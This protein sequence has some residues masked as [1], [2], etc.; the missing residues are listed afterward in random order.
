MILLT[1]HEVT[2]VLNNLN[3]A[4]FLSYTNYCILQMVP[5]E[6][7]LLDIRS[8]RNTTTTLVISVGKLCSLRILPLPTPVQCWLNTFHVTEVWILLFSNI[9]RGNGGAGSCFCRFL[10][11]IWCFYTFSNT[12]CPRLWFWCHSQLGYFCCRYW[13]VSHMLSAKSIKIRCV[14]RK[15]LLIPAELLGGVFFSLRLAVPLSW[16][17]EIPIMKSKSQVIITWNQGNFHSIKVSGQCVEQFV[18]LSIWIILQRFKI[19]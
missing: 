15:G 18:L 6:C 11:M 4:C 5:E 16:G 7:V 19:P 14:M 12:I 17:V 3:Y 10:A 8:K 1:D 2:H 13:T 9:E